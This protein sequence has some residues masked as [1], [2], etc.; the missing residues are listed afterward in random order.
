MLLTYI[1]ALHSE[2]H[3]KPINT[4]RGQ[5]SRYFYCQSKWQ[6]IV[7][8]VSER[9]EATPEIST[10]SLQRIVRFRAKIMFTRL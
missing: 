4:I 10:R 3:T 1:F 8:A 6:M 5:N 7:T 2:D 9:N